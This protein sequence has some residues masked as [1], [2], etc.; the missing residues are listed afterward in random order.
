[1]GVSRKISFSSSKEEL[2]KAAAWARARLE[3][4]KTR[5][6]VVVPEL[7]KRRREVV[8]VFARV[9][10][11]AKPFNVS[12]GAPLDE[13]PLVHAALAVLELA[14]R[15]VPFAAA[16]RLV[17][18]P[19]LGGGDSEMA[20]RA[21][22][23]VRLRKDSD[24]TVSLGKLIALSD[25]SIRP[26]LE[27]IFS[28]ERKA[29]TPSEWA[30]HFSAVLEAAGFPGERALDSEEFQAQAKW[31]EVLGELARL[32]RVSGKMNFENSFSVLK[33]L[34]HDTL[35]QPESGEAPVQI[36]GVLESAGTRFDCLWVS[37]LTDEAWPLPAS[38]NPFV[39]VA[40]QKKAGVPEAS[41]EAS[42]ALDA[43]LTEEWRGAAAE[44]VFSWPRKE[45]D[46]DLAPSSLIRDVPEGDVE[47]PAFPR[48]RDL[49]FAARKVSSI[50]DR[51]GPPVARANAMGGTRVL[52]D[53]AAC[54][55]RAFARHRLHADE[56]EEPRPGL[57][58]RD[59][60]TLIHTL[61]KELWSRVKSQA[62]LGANLGPAIAQA[63]EVAVKEAGLEGRFAEIERARLARVAADWLELEKQRQP[64]E[65]R[66][67]E[68]PVSISVAG[69]ELRG[70]IDRLDRL[71]D[72]THALIDYKTGKANHHTWD[73]PRQDE[74]Q[75]PLYAV[76]LKEPVSAVVF[77]RLKTG[78]MR[79]MGFSE[80]KG[81]IPKV[82]QAKDWQNLLDN[83]RKHAEEM[84][85]E[86]ASGE[87]RVAPKYDLKTCRNCDLQTLCRVYEKVN[88][89]EEGV[90]E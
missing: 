23:D 27:R 90:E 86:F 20:R 44:V 17:R 88:F 81:V 40:L 9:M 36:L 62:S 15:E 71:Q 82:E 55:F 89:L 56:L 18:S 65:V 61:M 79:F 29:Q 5:I 53:Q 70:R 68:Q 32:E 59:R 6:G 34:C 66:F 63:A 47:V 33:R 80:K 52:A 1:L 87:A 8:R 37:G 3:G 35:F 72:G 75:M 78:Q 7:G 57:D 38:P 49:I 2:E 12:L 43:R 39:P 54:P 76:N 4:G 19:F 31:H 84:A 85:R 69:L 46:R 50:E 51:A 30:R 58:A 41:A 64:F 24:S 21:R 25:A 60:G 48:Y 42:A 16:S 45:E 73:G 74:P 26:L 83:W 10:G 13:V 28:V 77:A 22:L 14:H 67:V 11:S